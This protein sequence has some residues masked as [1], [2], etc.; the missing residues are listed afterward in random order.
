MKIEA[1]SKDVSSSSG[2]MVWPIVVWGTKVVGFL[3]VCIVGL[4]Y[5]HQDKLL[6]IPNP[7][8]FPKTPDENPPGFTSPGEWTKE[9]RLVRKRGNTSQSSD[10]IPYEDTIVRTDDGASIHTWLLLQ[11]DNDTRKH[12]VLIYFHGNAGNMGFRLKNAVDMYSK[13][14][15]NVLMMD[16]RGYGKLSLLCL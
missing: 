15:I 12:P 16:Y 4:V 11:D 10:R 13:V 8:G 2:S 7:P 14:K 6:Y 3:F 9:G 1:V 5:Y